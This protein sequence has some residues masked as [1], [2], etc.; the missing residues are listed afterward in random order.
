MEMVLI[1]SKKLRKRRHTSNILTARDEEIDIV[2]GLDLG[3]EDY[4]VKPFR[5][6]ELISRIKVALRRYNKITS[7]IIECNGI[8]LDTEN[9]EAKKMVK[10][11]SLLV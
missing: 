1:S 7:S 8:T 11:S 6:K 5:V 10:E 2:K 9:M 4:I 3:A